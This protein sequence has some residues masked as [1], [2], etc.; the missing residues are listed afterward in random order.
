MRSGETLIKLAKHKVD[1]VQKLLAAAQKIKADL[2]KKQE[3]LVTAFK[4][5]QDIA[6]NTTGL[7][8]DFLAYKQSW[9]RQYANV[10][11]SIIGVDQEIETLGA[12]LQSGFEELKKFETLEERRQA[13]ATEQRKA[14]ELKAMDEFAI[15]RAKRG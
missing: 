6:V 7:S 12:E 14:R 1:N 11:A 9:D 8:A 3:D 13:Y 4:K 10:G 5:E 2:I 15:I